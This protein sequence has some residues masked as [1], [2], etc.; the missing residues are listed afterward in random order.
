VNQFLGSVLPTADSAG[1][2]RQMVA[3]P[4]RAAVRQGTTGTMVSAS[5]SEPFVEG[6]GWPV[7]GQAVLASRPAVGHASSGDAQAGSATSLDVGLPFDWQALLGRTRA[8]QGKTILALIG[9][10]A[11]TLRIR[12]TVA[13]KAAA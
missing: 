9:A 3:V 5:H 10:L 1:T 8:E 6:G 13:N 11:V 12:R 2:E 7:A 4:S